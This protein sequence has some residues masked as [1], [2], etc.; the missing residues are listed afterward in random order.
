LNLLR[1]HRSLYRDTV[2]QC[3]QMIDSA[4][5]K[6]FSKWAC[7]RD[8]RGVKAIIWSVLYVEIKLLAHEQK[9]ARS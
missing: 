5:V 4:A 6:W 1:W 7:H 8:S 9:L 3:I 2:T